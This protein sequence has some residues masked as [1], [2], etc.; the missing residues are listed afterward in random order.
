MGKVFAV[1]IVYVVWVVAL[2][3]LPSVTGL[4]VDRV[5][6]IVRKAADTLDRV[7]LFFGSLGLVRDMLREGRR[8]GSL[9]ERKEDCDSAGQQHLRNLRSLRSRRISSGGAEMMYCA[10]LQAILQLTRHVP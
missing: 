8:S 9:A 10:S 4:A 3:V 5:S 1:S 2:D 7:G 6:I